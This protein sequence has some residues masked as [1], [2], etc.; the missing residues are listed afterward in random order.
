MFIAAALLSAAI[1]DRLMWVAA[2][3][4][5]IGAIGIVYGLGAA[6]FYSLGWFVALVATALLIARYSI[7]RRQS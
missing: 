4:A 2:L 6:P 7:V 1:R 3:L 5:I